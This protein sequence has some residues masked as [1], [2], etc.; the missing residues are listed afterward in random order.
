MMIRL[1][2]LLLGYDETYVENISHDILIFTNA[3]I[4]EIAR[5]Y[6]DMPVRVIY[7]EDEQ[8]KTVMNLLP[9]VLLLLIL[10]PLL[11]MALVYFLGK[12]V[13]VNIKRLIILGFD[14]KRINRSYMRFIYGIGFCCVLFSMIISAGVL[15]AFTVD[16]LAVIL[17]GI[18]CVLSIAVMMVAGSVSIRRIWRK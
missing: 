18:L 10:F 14:R 5:M 17:L 15:L 4:D 2:R 13:S 8:Q 16:H 11:I 6:N 9:Y 3:R 1:R 7:R 12:E